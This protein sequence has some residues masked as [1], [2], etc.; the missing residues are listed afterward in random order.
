MEM[1]GGKDI[2]KSCRT[3]DIMADAAYVI[4]TRSARDFTGNFVVDEEILKEE[5]CRD[6]EQY[7]CVPGSELLPDFFLVRVISISREL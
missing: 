3:V 5:G 4:L 1:L 2:G 6:F 7:A